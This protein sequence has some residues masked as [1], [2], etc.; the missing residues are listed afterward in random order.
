MVHLSSR[1]TTAPYL[2]QV[3]AFLETDTLC[4]LSEDYKLFAQQQQIWTPLRTAFERL[5]EVKLAVT[6]GS[7]IVPED[8]SGEV[9]DK[10]REK[11]LGL[12]FW[13]LTAL[14]Q[15]ATACKSLV[16]GAMLVITS[17]S[18]RTITATQVLQASYL[19]EDFQAGF[20]GEDDTLVVKKE[21][22]LRDLEACRE[23]AECMG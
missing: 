7:C 2:L 18:E 15:A 16:C 11:L 23:F 19:E 3:L 14:E 22:L 9:Y 1:K 21:G 17:E 20:W 5:F 10:V 13:H 4:F 12:N 6:E 8:H